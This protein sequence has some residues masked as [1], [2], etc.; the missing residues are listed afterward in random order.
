[1]LAAF[2]KA[3]FINPKTAVIFASLYIGRPDL[4]DDL[5]DICMR[6]SRCQ[7][8]Q[9]HEID[10]HISDN[11]WYGQTNIGSRYRKKGIENKHLDKRCQKRKAAGGWA[12]HGSWGMSAGTHWPYMPPCYQP[13][14]LDDLYTAALLAARKYERVCWETNT[15]HTKHGWCKVKKKSRKNNLPSPKRKNKRKIERP[16]N[17]LEFYI[18]NP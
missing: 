10:A 4:V 12:T 3:L 17:W 1:M 5:I 7:E 2:F 14:D 8:I 16:S 11:E 15:K 13:E 18:V 9:T 6:E